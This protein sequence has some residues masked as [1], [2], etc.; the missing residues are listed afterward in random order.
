MPIYS[1]MQ[2]Y[3]TDVVS[4][5]HMLSQLDNEPLSVPFFNTTSVD[6]IYHWYYLYDKQ[7][8]G[9]SHPS[10][11][12]SSAV[13]Q[14]VNFHLNSI[15]NEL[16]KN[17][18]VHGPSQQPS[19][20]FN[21]D[22]FVIHNL[23]G[24]NAVEMQSIFL[25]EPA[26]QAMCIA[27]P[28]RF[29]KWIYAST[30]Q[31]RYRYSGAHSENDNS[32]KKEKKESNFDEE[33]EDSKIWNFWEWLKSMFGMDISQDGTLARCHILEVMIPFFKGQKG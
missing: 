33:L 5:S 14:L 27:R 17:Q 12:D 18:P 7:S 4:N 23:D 13:E 19:S 22:S 15:Q 30:L 11:F 6:Y 26:D 1:D 16:S 3:I 2:Q 28:F 32:D 9:D 25:F 31:D 10:Q 20:N 24:N 21:S 8:S 29:H